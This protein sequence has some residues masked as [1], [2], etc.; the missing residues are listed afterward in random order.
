M[1]TRYGGLHVL[2]DDD[3]VWNRDPVAQAELACAGG[4]QVIQ[5]R[6]KRAADKQAYLW[7]MK[8]REMTRAAGIRFVVNDRFDIALESGADAVHLGQ[9]DISPE[10]VRELA[11]DAIHIGRSTHTL[12]EATRALF[13]PVDYVAFGPVFGTTSK[14]SPYTARG[15]PALEEVVRRVAPL[16]V[17]AIG[18]IEPGHLK[19]LGA[20]GVK[21]IAVISQVAGADDAT[22]A[23][24]EL[25]FAF[26]NSGRPSS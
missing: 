13:E 9:E 12:E 2:V 19:E 17:V 21:G 15:L 5:L 6:A 22:A 26:E 24:R 18:G 4:A 25:A 7:A 8:L 11:G 20:T 14:K 16:P 3:P 23:T 1:N 10:E